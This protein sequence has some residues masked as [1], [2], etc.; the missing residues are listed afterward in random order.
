MRRVEGLDMSGLKA[1]GDLLE[2]AIRDDVIGDFITEFL[3]ELA[4]RLDAKVKPRTPVS[5]GGGNLR[6]NWT[7]G[8]VQKLPGKLYRIEYFNNTEY[9]GYVENGHR[10]GADRTGWVEG[11]FMLKISEEEIEREMQRFLDKKLE[12]ALQDYFG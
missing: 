3:L 2:K 9:A 7:V 11:R 6:R 4:Y 10:T 5:P 8:E 1:F 12:K